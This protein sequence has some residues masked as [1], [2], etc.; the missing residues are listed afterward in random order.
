MSNILNGHIGERRKGALA[1]VHMYVNTLHEIF[2]TVGAESVPR[3]TYVHR[4]MMIGGD[5]GAQRNASRAYRDQPRKVRS[6]GVNTRGGGGGPMNVERE[7]CSN[8]LFKI[9]LGRGLVF[10][11]RDAAQNENRA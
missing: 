6:E 5:D 9:M 1:S 8:E 10:G 7:N 4:Y 3:A 11:Q 2:S